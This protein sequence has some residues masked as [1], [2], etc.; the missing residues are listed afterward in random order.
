MVQDLGQ[1]GRREALRLC[2]GVQGSV[3][4]CHVVLWRIDKAR[5]HSCP[6]Y[7]S[8][9]SDLNKEIGKTGHEIIQMSRGYGK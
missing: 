4:R 7:S 2:E 9:L 1:L 5:K 6:A 8:T 3:W